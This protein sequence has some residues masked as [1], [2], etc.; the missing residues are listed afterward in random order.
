MNT[1]VKIALT[2]A[3]AASATSAMADGS[4]F[5]MGLGFGQAKN[6][7][8]LSKNDVYN[9]MDVVASVLDID[10]VDGSLSASSG[11]SDTAWKI[12]A[13]YELNKN[14]AAELS[15]VDLGTFEAKGSA[16]GDFYDAGNNYLFT[17]SGVVLA[18]G[19]A[20]AFT[21][22]GVGKFSPAQWVE[23]FGKVGVYQAKS[24]NRKAVAFTDGVNVVADTYS[25]QDH[26]TGLHFG[27]GA[28]FNVLEHVAIRA[29]WERFSDVQ[30]FGA[31]ANVELMSISA[32]YK[33]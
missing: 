20:Q 12:F 33:F 14:F 13:G 31:D 15:Y 2:T 28:D 27:F 11:N 6:Q 3:I 24:E 5:Y 17:G 30:F 1:L 10:S 29:E 25:N 18:K 26:T 22:D 8:W 21:L 4:K 19:E 23:L 16:T 32:I 9:A 7:D